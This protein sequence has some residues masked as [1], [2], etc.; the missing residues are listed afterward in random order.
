MLHM[1]EGV[2]N[3]MKSSHTTRKHLA[4]INT[5]GKCNKKEQKLNTD[6]VM[7]LIKSEKHFHYYSQKCLQSH[8]LNVEA[9]KI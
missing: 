5:Y 3:E 8:N 6:T 7:N 9:S 2:L 1:M 4:E